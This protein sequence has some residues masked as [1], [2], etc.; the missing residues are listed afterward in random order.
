MKPK[1]TPGR[2]S[3]M[4]PNCGRG[5]GE[6]AWRKRFGDLEFETAEYVCQKHWSLVP[7]KMRRAYARVRRRERKF[8]VKLPAS[9]RLW[10]RM[11]RE[12]LACE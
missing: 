12:I 7:E 11:V 3:C 6:D 4:A 9:A 2:L 5:I 1:Q 8:G 10:R